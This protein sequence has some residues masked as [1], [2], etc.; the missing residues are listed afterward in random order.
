MVLVNAST[1]WSHVCLL[2]T[3]NLVF[4]SLLTQIIKLRAQFSNYIIK[5]IHLNNA[6]EFTS[7]VF[8]DYCMSFGIN[9]K[10][11][12]AHVHTQNGL[13]KSLIKY[14]QLLQNDYS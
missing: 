10:H 4:A 13:A 14:L 5:S 2:S 11:L 3:H 8:N 1:R 12:V 7:Q 6:D 9:I